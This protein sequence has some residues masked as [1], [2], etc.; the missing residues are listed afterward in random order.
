MSQTT[1]GRYPRL[2][3]G[4][5]T[6]RT[7]NGITYKFEKTETGWKRGQRVTPYLV[8]ESSCAIR[9]GI[10]K[11]RE[12]RKESPKYVKPAKPEVK[13]LPDRKEDMTGM[14]WV[15]IDKRTMVLRKFIIQ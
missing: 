15:K 4:S 1:K 13:R 9:D 5:I 3:I 6:E 14:H 8:P 11:S 10:R 2:Q 12:A 7:E